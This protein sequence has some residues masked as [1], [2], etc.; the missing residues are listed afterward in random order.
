MKRI[1]CIILKK[2]TG[3]LAPQ[4]KYYFNYII[5]QFITLL[6]NLFNPTRGSNTSRINKFFATLFS[7]YICRIINIFIFWQNEINNLKGQFTP[8]IIKN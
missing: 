2:T 1:C 8:R 6:K 5:L 3:G 7:N 4:E